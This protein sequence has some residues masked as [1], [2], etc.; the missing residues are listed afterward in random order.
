MVRARTRKK[1]RKSAQ[2]TKDAQE[3]YEDYTTEREHLSKY[4]QANY[5]N[6]EK[7][8][9]TLSAAFLAFSVSFLGLFRNKTASGVQL[10]P[11]RCPNLLIWSWISFGSSILF[12]L[13]CFLVNAMALRAEVCELEKRLTEA[14]APEKRNASE[15][16]N[17]SE[18]LNIW[19]VFGYALYAFS[20]I[21][22]ILGLVL[23]LIFCARNIHI[24]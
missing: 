11:L 14:T 19:T 3:A 20:G 8:I 4:E 9:L 13:L 1:Q 22:F 21:A 12:L 23:L 17:G 7:A 6:Y 2:Q 5:D 24:F 15:E 18:E 10:P 16:R